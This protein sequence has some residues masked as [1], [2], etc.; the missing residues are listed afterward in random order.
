MQRPERLPPCGGRSWTE[1]SWSIRVLPAAMTTGQLW[2]RPARWP[3]LLPSRVE[4]DLEEGHHLTLGVEAE[5]V[6]S[7][8]PQL[9]RDPSLFGQHA[10]GGVDMV[11]LDDV[12]GRRAVDQDPAPAAPVPASVEGELAVEF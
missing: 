9:R 11:G 7:D 6:I 2:L 5:Q 1:I 3:R 10:T 8:Q 12:L 4:V